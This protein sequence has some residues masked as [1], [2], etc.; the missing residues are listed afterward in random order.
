MPS[1]IAGMIIDVDYLESEEMGCG[2]CEFKVVQSL[3][4][5]HSTQYAYA[6]PHVDAYEL[7]MSLSSGIGSLLLLEIGDN[8]DYHILL[9]D[10]DHKWDESD[11]PYGDT[12]DEWFM[13]D[14]EGIEE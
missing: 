10:L 4:P 2:L 1:C 8:G 14:V 6:A 13:D 11:R 7:T 5:Y 9:Y 12:V 3:T